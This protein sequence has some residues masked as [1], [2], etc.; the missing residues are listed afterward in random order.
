MI[1]QY[2]NRR[3]VPI[4][5]G[6]LVTIT[7]IL[8][9]KYEYFL[10][11]APST[12]VDYYISNYGYT[13]KEI[14]FIDAA[15]YWSYMPAQIAV[16]TVMDHYG[17]RRP[18]FLAIFSCIFGSILFGLEQSYYLVLLG[19][20]LIGFGS[21]F[22]FVAVLKTASV[23]LPKRQFALAVGI[24][25]S[26]GMLGAIL[27]LILMTSLVNHYGVQPTIDITIALGLSLVIAVYFMV[28][29][30]KTTSRKSHGK[31]RFSMVFK[32]FFKVIREPQMWLIGFIGIALYLPTQMFSGLWAMP[33]FVHIRKLQPEVASQISSLLYWGWIVGSPIVGYLSEYVPNKRMILMTGAILCAIMLSLI[34]YLPITSLGLLIPAMFL[35]GLFSSTQ[36]LVFD[37]ATCIIHHTYS[38]TAVAITNMFV[39]FGGVLQSSIGGIIESRSTE[40]QVFTEA[41]FQSAFMI[42]PILCILS[43]FVTL[44]MREHKK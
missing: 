6:W 36:I 28:F 16:G 14:G 25:T 40:T 1:K 42:M 38:G 43:V 32:T 30:R 11:L 41:G 31:K 34:I 7:V 27:S 39:T 24:A 9:Y 5:V 12:M 19:R 15:Y 29:D 23:W 37:I 22:G 44:V 17:V 21:A 18:L 20:F 26:L 10:R 2:I 13:P 4:A 35:L 8:F 3:N 33:Y